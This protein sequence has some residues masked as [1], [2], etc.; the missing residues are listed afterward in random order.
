MV[1]NY[2]I[3]QLSCFLLNQL[4]AVLWLHSMFPDSRDGT[5]TLHFTKFSEKNMKKTLVPRIIFAVNKS[6]WTS[7]WTDHIWRGCVDKHYLLNLACKVEPYVPPSQWRNQLLYPSLESPN[8][9]NYT[10]QSRAIG[11]TSSCK[12]AM[13]NNV[14]Y[15]Y[16]CWKF[17]FQWFLCTSSYV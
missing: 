7:E 6:T 9:N 5:P 14:I 10:S 16:F 1:F 12:P 17:Q 13:K 4:E 15:K 11:S 8:P 2:P 3:G